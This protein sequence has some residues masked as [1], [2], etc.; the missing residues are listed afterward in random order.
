VEDEDILLDFDPN[1]F[2]IRLN[3]VVDENGEWN[4]D[5]SV[6]IVTTPENELDDE[7][8]DGMMYLT[9]MVTASLP[10]MED[11]VEFRSQLQ[12]Y[13]KKLHSE[14]KGATPKATTEKIADNVIK[15]KF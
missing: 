5:V 12:H 8:F 13:M 2:L 9:M 10:L 1:D 14:E 7:D 3:P 15:L 11:N 6:G 4:G